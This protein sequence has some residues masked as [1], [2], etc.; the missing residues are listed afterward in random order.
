M[1]MNLPMLKKNS[2]VIAVSQNGSDIK[3]NAFGPIFTHGHDSSR[4]NSSVFQAS[5]SAKWANHHSLSC[6]YT[7][8][9]GSLLIILV[10]VGLP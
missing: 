4:E 3:N 7:S 5:F 10:M 1:F 9:I 6:N 2:E 8:A